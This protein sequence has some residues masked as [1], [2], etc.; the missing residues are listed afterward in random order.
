[1]T[2]PIEREAVFPRM[3]GIRLNL[4]KLRELQTRGLEEFRTRKDTFDLAQHHLRLALEG[5]FNIAG[6]ILSRMPGGRATEYKEIAR[7]LG[8]LDIVS[9]AFADQTLVPMG[10][11]RNIL[12]HHYT[13]IDPDRLYDVLT[14]HLGDIEAFL[15]FIGGVLTHPE[16]FGL[17]V[18]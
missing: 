8:E 1:M 12:V 9:R 15:G 17:T 11:M 13:E 14:N 4:Q 2:L 7:K 16:K 3:S 18:E 6:H 5:I 10:G